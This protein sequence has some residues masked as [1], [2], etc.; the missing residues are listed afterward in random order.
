MDEE[1][2]RYLDDMM[3][4]IN[5]KFDPL[6]EAVTRMSDDLRQATAAL[7]RR[8]DGKDHSETDRA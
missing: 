3:A 2:R 6:H 7:R 1:L 8:R 5:A 4:Q